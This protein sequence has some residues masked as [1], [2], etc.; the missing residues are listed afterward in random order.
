MSEMRVEKIQCHL[1]GG[2]SDGARISHAPSVTTI[3]IPTPTSLGYSFVVYRKQKP[4]QRSND[5]AV[6]F[7]Y[8]LGE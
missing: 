2:P 1:V 6:E 7:H 4:E 3:K 8:V 5:G